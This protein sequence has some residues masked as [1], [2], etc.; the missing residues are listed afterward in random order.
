MSDSNSFLTNL[1]N[2]VIYKAHKIAYDPEANEFAKKAEPEDKTDKKG[3]NIS[4]I[5]NFL[6]IP[7]KKPDTTNTKDAKDTTTTDSD[8]NTFSVTRMIKKTTAT[9]SSI[10]TLGII[11]FIAL[12][13]AMVVANDMIVYSVPIR[14]IF[15]VFILI[16]SIIIPLIPIIIT[17]VYLFKGGYVM[18][19]KHVRKQVDIPTILPVIFSLLPITTHIP[20]SKLGSLLLYPF[21]YPK[22]EEGVK[23]LTK[24]MDDYKISLEQSFTDYDSI[25]K[26]MPISKRVEE[27]TKFLSSLNKIPEHPKKAQEEPI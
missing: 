8:P 1:T 3:G 5:K 12:M 25:E 6:G 14:V 2:K 20:S 9:F 18:Y 24:V 16:S 4:R 27:M 10:I 26:T 21:R 17:I 19:L 22:T 13:T 11:P 7:E 23:K 15:F